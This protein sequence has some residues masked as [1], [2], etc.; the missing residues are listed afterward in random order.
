MH[1]M[2]KR[3]PQSIDDLATRAVAARRALIA[4][5]R[6]NRSALPRHD[7]EVLENV[8]TDLDRRGCF[9]P[10]ALESA[11]AVVARLQAAV[12]RAGGAPVRRW[13]EEGDG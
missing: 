11:D 13:T 1:H 5:T 3:G 7:R 4:A 8:L 10:D 2:N 6:E 9:A 12:A